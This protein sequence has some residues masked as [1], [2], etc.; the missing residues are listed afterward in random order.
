APS[1]IAREAAPVVDSGLRS[2]ILG[3]SQTTTPEAAA[4]TNGVLIRFLDYNDTYLSKEPAHP[5]D[6]IAACLAAA[7]A[8]GRGGKDFLTA[9]V[10]AYEIQLR[11]CDGASLRTKGWDHV[12]YGA[13]S[14]VSAAS[15]LLG[16]SNKETINAIN[17]A[18]T[19]SPALRQS[20]AG[21]LSMWKG[22][23]FANT[24]KDAVFAAILAHAGMTGPSP[25][26]EGEF[27][28]EKIVSGPI[29]LSSNFGGENGEGFK[30]DETYIKFYPAEYHS[31]SAIG[32]AIDLRSE[33]DDSSE[34]ES[35]TVKT[36][37]TG[38][39]IIGKGA[40]KWRP[41][42]RETADHS[43]P[44]LVAAAILD[45][46]VSLSTYSERMEDEDLL[47]FTAKVKVEVDPDM[48]RMYPSAIP[49][50]V[51]VRLKSGK[52]ITAEM[53]YPKGHPKNPM[54]DHEVE[55][56]FKALGAW[57]ITGKKADE[58]LSKIWALEKMADIKELMRLF[59]I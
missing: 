10:A 44:F 19:I 26:F 20:R 14:S 48:D 51:E 25:I 56:K 33:I 13:F 3:S 24:S 38:Y 42:T 40:E 59:R 29:E 12:A 46:S 16:L 18:G 4:F 52:H 27:G 5:S 57:A 37:Q 6:N 55:E 54:T 2:T 9:I 28:F 43:L 8:A 47:E 15:M 58:I 1:R 7:E 35:I 34:V 17:I 22:C 41:R 31:Q 32:A 21:E 11:L 49:N 50:R 36:F 39:D 23:A 45:G 30:I 53:I